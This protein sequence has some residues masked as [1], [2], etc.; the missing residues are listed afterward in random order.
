MNIIDKELLLDQ[1]NERG[2][3]YGG[4]AEATQ[5][6]RT[7]LYNVIEGKNCPSYFL[8]DSIIDALE[9]SKEDTIKIFFSNSKFKGDIEYERSY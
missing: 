7:A 2:F 6:S 3:N 5:F 1:M 9:L 4:L 8:I